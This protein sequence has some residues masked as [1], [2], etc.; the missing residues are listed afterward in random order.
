MSVPNV[1][2]KK[3]EDLV[4][5]VVL[6]FFNEADVIPELVARLRAAFKRA[7]VR[8]ELLFVN[9]ASTDNSIEVLK[10]QAVGHSDILIIDMARNFG[11]MPCIFAGIHEARGD[12]L[13]Y[14]D[15]D[16]QDPPELIPEMI[17]A[18]LSEEGVDS[19]YTTRR[20]RDGESFIKLWITNVGYRILK[21]TSNI[22]IAVNSGDYRLI[23]RRVV[24]ELKKFKEK[25]P[26][27]RFLVTWVGF[28]QKQVFYD[29]EARF[30]GQTKF[31]IFGQKVFVQFLE[32]SLVP[33]SDLPLR[34]CLLLGFLTS[35]LALMY[36]VY[37]I[38]TRLAGGNLPGWTALMAVVLFLGGI[39][40]I[41]LGILGLY[42]GAIH[43]EVKGRPNYIVKDR[44][45][46]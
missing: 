39:Q 28:K 45:G 2:P 37:V 19:V 27:F 3:R 35:A 43:A 8:H 7:G 29:R 40:L 10:Q 23:S 41:V 30:A 34:L 24:D 36:M 4:V 21:Y 18:W 1:A 22:N 25:K 13:I 26:F 16:L 11:H 46:F 20:R 44:F 33:F 15:A 9:D 5:T 14:M 38:L 12:A 31:P 42:I 32:I 17:D 6:S